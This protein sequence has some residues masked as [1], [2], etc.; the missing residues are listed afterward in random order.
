MTRM[1]DDLMVSKMLVAEETRYVE[2]QKGT[3][4]L[5]LFEHSK[6]AYSV[7]RTKEAAGPEVTS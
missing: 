2:F 7:P 4:V 6:S 3:A 5:K 1:K